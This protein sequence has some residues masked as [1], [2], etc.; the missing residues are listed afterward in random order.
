M[1]A[2]VAGKV[3]EVVVVRD[4]LMEFWVVAGVRCF[5]FWD[6]VFL[7]DNWV[8]L[9]LGGGDRFNKL[10]LGRLFVV[11]FRVGN[12]EGFSTSL[13]LLSGG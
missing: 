4:K 12:L 8:S 2:I 5:K 1:E 9:G 11:M 10:E 7:G 13:L 6:G 3:I